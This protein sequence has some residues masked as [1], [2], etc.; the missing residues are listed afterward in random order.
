VQFNPNRTAAPRCGTQLPRLV[1]GAEEI[2]NAGPI[3][4]LAGEKM[5]FV[6]R[7]ATEKRPPVRIP[8]APQRG[9]AKRLLGCDPVRVGNG[10]GQWPT[11]PKIAAAVTSA[12]SSRFR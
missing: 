8:A 10:E 6:P 11:D 1:A 9:T 7:T 12:A 3:L 5:P 2:R 4:T